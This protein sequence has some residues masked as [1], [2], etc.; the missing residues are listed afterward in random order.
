M[1]DSLIIYFLSA[2]LISIAG[3][4]GYQKYKKFLLKRKLK[5]R[6]TFAREGEKSAEE[7]LKENGYALEEVQKGSKLSMYV[8][9]EEFFYQVRPDGFA[10]KEGK[11]YLVEVKTGKVATNPKSS[12]TRRQLLEYYHGFDV[13]GV[14]LID[15]QDKKVHHVHFDVKEVPLIEEV[16][17]ANSKLKLF[18]MFF[19]GAIFAFI[20]F[21]LM[22]GSLANL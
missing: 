14:L 8:N 6:F 5:K 9:G 19:L 4:Y 2:L 1:S 11:R 21:W 15:S 16:Q 12:A 10:S 22:R 7:L 3:A 18:M 20:M 17:V 13:E